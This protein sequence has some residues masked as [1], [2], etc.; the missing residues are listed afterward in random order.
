LFIASPKTERV[1]SHISLPKNTVMSHL[2]PDGSPAAHGAKT[3][4]FSPEAQEHYDDAQVRRTCWQDCS[5]R[6]LEQIVSNRTR[7]INRHNHITP[8]SGWFSGNTR[9][10]NSSVFSRKT[11]ASWCRPSALYVTARLCIAVPR[12]E[13]VK[14]RTSNQQTQSSHLCPDGSLATYVDKTRASS[15]AEPEHLGAAQVDCTNWQDCSLRRLEQNV[16]N[17][18]RQ[19]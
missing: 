11:R 14:S 4:A 16:S 9:R 10:R 7:Q 13:R 3:Q 6:R 2:F 17:R 18:T 8:M 12:T 1:K 19:I 5:L 15:L